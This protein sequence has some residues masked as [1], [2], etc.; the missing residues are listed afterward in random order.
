MLNGLGSVRPYRITIYY[1]TRMGIERPNQY[2]LLRQFSSDLTLIH[3]NQKI[4]LYEYL[5]PNKRW[6]W[7]PNIKMTGCLIYSLVIS[8]W[9]ISNVRF[10]VWCV[11]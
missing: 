7:T 4:I 10:H 6:F 2:G 1:Q 3:S 8:S 9:Q 5:N 11:S